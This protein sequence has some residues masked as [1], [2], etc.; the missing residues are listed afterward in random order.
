MKTLAIILACLALA[1]CAANGENGANY[2]GKGEPVIVSYNAPDFDDAAE[3]LN[4]GD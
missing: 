3:F 1:A 4:S 2:N